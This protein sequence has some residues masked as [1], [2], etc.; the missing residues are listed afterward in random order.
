MKQKNKEKRDDGE[1]DR[2]R[3]RKEKEKLSG[4]HHSWDG[5]RG[6]ISMIF[7]RKGSQA[8]LRMQS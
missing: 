3:G 4:P 8:L 1:D 7:L 6:Q 5:S 2:R